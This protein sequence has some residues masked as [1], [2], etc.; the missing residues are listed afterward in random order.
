MDFEVMLCNFTAGVEAV[1][2]LHLALP[3]D[4]RSSP[5][6]TL[7]DSDT[8]TRMFEVLHSGSWHNR[9][10]GESRI[11]LDLTGLVSLYDT[12]LAPS[13]IPVR[14][15]LERYDHRVLGISS[16]DTSRV[17]RKLIKVITRPHPVGSGIDWKT[18]T[19]VIVDRYADR[20]E[21]MQYLL[22]FT[23]SDSQQLL[24]QAKLAQAQLRVMLMP[25]L[26]HS[27]I[28]PSAVTS[29][30]DALQWALPI[31]RQCAITH[32]SKIINQI[33]LMTSSERLLLTAVE[34]TTREICRVTTNM[35]AN[36]VMSG[37]DTLFHVEPNVDRKITRL[38]SDWKQDVK[39]L[40]SWLDWSIW[41]KCRPAC[42]TEEM[43]YLP[44]PMPRHPRPKN[45]NDALGAKSPTDR[46]GPLPEG[47]AITGSPFVHATL[48]EDPRKRQPRCIRRFQPYL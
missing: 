18:L 39:K 15:G 17:M 19:H 23:S 22:N 37:L 9:Y 41:V 31:F 43:C 5:H 7:L 12:A 20:L 13:L 6:P 26:L 36:G 10:P 16:D 35:W 47:L 44:N 8:G 27:T 45:L 38:M 30:V 14:A 4:E 25:Y 3:K 33:P 48:E 28:V 46:V 1:S 42:G 34:D 29:G 11:V 21:L 32:T 2:F 24:H 40:M